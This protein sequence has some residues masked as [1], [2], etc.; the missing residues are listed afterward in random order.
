MNRLSLLVTGA[1]LHS[2][3]YAATATNRKSADPLGPTRFPKEQTAGLELEAIASPFENFSKDE[4]EKQTVAAQ[5]RAA[6]FAG[7]RRDIASASWDASQSE[8]YK[9]FRKKFLAIKST[10]ALDALLADLEANYDKHPADLKL[11]ALSLASVRDFR[12]FVFRAS[13]I[14]DQS[15]IIKSQVMT[16]ISRL[17]RSMRIHMPGAHH[18]I[19][20]DYVN[21]PDPALAKSKGY[22]WTDEDG[23]RAFFV[24]AVYPTH[25]Q[26]V[27]RLKALDLSP[28]VVID[29]QF[30]ATPL[31][32]SDV[33][34]A[35][36]IFGEAE[37]NN[38][39]SSLYG[40]LY[41]MAFVAAHSM[42]SMIE[43]SYELGK[44]VW[45]DS[46]RSDDY[47]AGIT[48]FEV[49]NVMRKKRFKHYFN[50]MPKN[51]PAW[52]ISAHKHLKASVD[53]ALLYWNE[54]KNQPVSQKPDFDP[55]GILQGFKDT[56]AHLLAMKEFLTKRTEV[57]SEVTGETAVID[58]P[59]Y[60]ANPP[61]DRKEMLPIAW[62]GVQNTG[63]ENWDSGP[64]IT[65]QRFV[66][67]K[68]DGGTV[69]VPDFT[70]GEPVSW[71]LGK[72]K[73]YFP[74]VKND[75]DLETALRVL[76]QSWGAWLPAIPFS[77]GLLM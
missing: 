65:A 5:K 31:K 13:P 22:R 15:S 40:E 33:A 2:L 47:I 16:G 34:P 20:Q 37:R 38:L 7:I 48:N 72:Y 71:N 3:S 66:N 36:Q 67:H 45:S 75:K 50:L 60:F 51:G 42:N 35:T 44:L 25:V 55:A 70:I 61:K 10:N 49:V 39:L 26:M 1:A 64:S 58:I 62:K 12:G 54:I 9:D 8:A 59:N 30:L 19:V 43:L 14:F 46:T 21:Q 52:M 74:E 76:D 57:R 24:T 41:G 11:V 32:S 77:F 28:P 68:V 56:E 73:P 6:S 23:L 27:K 17:F 53:Y 69:K 4:F 29:S 18:A 63:S